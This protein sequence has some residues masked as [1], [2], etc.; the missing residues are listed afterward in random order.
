[1]DR[2]IWRRADDLAFVASPDRVVL[3]LLR[4]LERPP[5]ILEGSAAAIW[6]AVDGRRTTLDVIDEVATLL[7]VDGLEIHDDVAGFLATLED[8][9]LVIPD[10]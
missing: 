9:G 4:Q 6:S 3:I 1:M 7:A 8:E 10:G 5:L 2:P